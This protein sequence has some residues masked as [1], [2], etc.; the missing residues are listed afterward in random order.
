MK[1]PKK[2][3]P[4]STEIFEIK[5]KKISIPK[6]KIEFEKW[7][8]IPLKNTFGGKPCVNF[9]NSGMFAELAIMNLFVE[10]NWNARWIETY[11][12]PKLKPIHLTNWNEDGYKSQI[13]N[14]ID[15]EK[16]QNLLNEIA[17]INDNNF[18]GIWDV[19]AWKNGEIIFAES[20]WSKKD[21]IQT[22][23]YKWLKSAFEFGL[24]EENFLMVEWNFKK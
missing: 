5:E 19:V 18:G 1:Y 17:K 13:H 21:F 7:N 8:G 14:G 4:N 23:Q 2:L 15:D 6:S 10:D 9:N 12:K 24:N 20:K 22:T 3:K 16:I 11:G